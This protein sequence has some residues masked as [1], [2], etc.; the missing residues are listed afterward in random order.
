MKSSFTIILLIVFLGIGGYVWWAEKDAPTPEELAKTKLLALRFDPLA[1]DGVVM[2]L[3]EEKLTLAKETETGTWRMTVPHE[4]RADQ[5]VVQNLI[6]ALAFL[7]V[8]DRFDAMDATKYNMPVEYAIGPKVTLFSGGKQVGEILIGQPASFE[9]SNYVQVLDE[10]GKPE[11][12]VVARQLASLVP[13][14]IGSW[15]DS[16]LATIDP[17]EVIRFAVKSPSGEVELV[18]EDKGQPWKFS[19]P[20]ETFA[21]GAVIDDLV[22]LLAE[23]RVEK[24]L[25]DPLVSQPDKSLASGSFTLATKQREINVTLYPYTNGQSGGETS[26]TALPPPPDALPPLVATCS[27]RVG[28]FRVPGD[29]VKL[30]ALQPNQLRDKRLGRL[31][32]RVFN[33][34]DIRGTDGREIRLR[35]PV[36][37]WLLEVT[38]GQGIPAD[39]ARVSGLFRAI[40]QA[41]IKDFVSDSLA[42][43]EIYGLHQ[44]MMELVFR[45]MVPTE[46][47]GTPLPDETATQQEILR[48][49][50]DASG[51]LYGNWDGQPF[52]YLL[53]PTLLNSIP[54]HVLRW[55]ATT[56][57]RFSVLSL[58]EALFEREGNPPFILRFDPTIMAWK[59][60]SEGK[61]LTAQLDLPMVDRLGSRL[62]NFSASEWVLEAGQARQELRKPTL[63][64]KL[65]VAQSDPANPANVIPAIIHLHFAPLSRSPD[66][67]DPRLYYGMM[68]GL[69]DPFYI[70]GEQFQSLLP[71]A[72]LRKDGDPGPKPNVPDLPPLVAPPPLPP[73]V[74]PDSPPET[75]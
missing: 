34:I 70:S 23:V 6:N 38:D 28:R 44:P 8:M 55:R 42:T 5:E 47:D 35:R 11:I 26:G 72:M 51:N 12:L 18:R 39:S 1:V 22:A 68:D 75:P 45:E 59:A 37:R 13:I 32:S 16:R 24:F 40:N 4:D 15:R 62:A 73:V 43:P 74:A 10:K 54:L 69:A 53:D 9:N 25:D 33:S 36:D 2:E 64:I 48:L 7:P 17:K 20:M 58:R 3:G 31:G 46:E 41:E 49:G 57:L 52:V 19:K 65:T 63:S 56:V 71:E 67:S 50:Q 66:A 29:L 60:E 14:G 61:D 30:L 21:Q 27:D